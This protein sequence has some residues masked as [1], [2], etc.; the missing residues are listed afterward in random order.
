MVIERGPVG[1]MQVSEAGRDPAFDRGDEM[2]TFRISMEFPENLRKTAARVVDT[3]LRQLVAEARDGDEILHDRHF[4]PVTVSVRKSGC[5][6]PASQDD[7]MR[8]VYEYIFSF[9]LDRDNILAHRSNF[10]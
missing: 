2:C 3:G 4:F 5:A 1:K 6:C 9:L 7:D 10:S 8:A